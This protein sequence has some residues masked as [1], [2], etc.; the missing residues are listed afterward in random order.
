MH[1]TLSVVMVG[2]LVVGAAACGPY[3]GGGIPSNAP[4]YRI[5]PGASTIIQPGVQAGYGI[6]ANSGGVYRLVW[7]GD[8]GSSGVRRSFYGSV[9]TPGS[10]LQVVAGCIS[11]VCPMESSDVVR[12]PINVNGGQRVDFDATTS[13]GI[14]G[15]DVQVDFEPVYFDLVIDGGRYPNL[16]F[17][18]ATDN[19]GAISPA[20]AMPFGLQGT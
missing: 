12:N 8:Q 6:T 2:A 7:T 15:F 3:T 4:V 17:F 14:D 9:W 1:K 5:V 19:G 13:D 18:S 11:S 16:V 10:F 20:G